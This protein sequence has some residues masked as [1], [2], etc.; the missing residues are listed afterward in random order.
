MPTLEK[1]V[2]LINVIQIKDRRTVREPELFSIELSRTFGSGSVLNVGRTP[3]LHILNF[4]TVTF[5]PIVRLVP[6]FASIIIF[7][8]RCHL[9]GKV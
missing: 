9:K 8:F 5:E 1:R 4:L 7:Q 2:I 3:A 6:N